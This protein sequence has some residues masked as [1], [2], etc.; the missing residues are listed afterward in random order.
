LSGNETKKEDEIKQT[1]INFNKI[2]GK[3][4]G[5]EWNLLE[6]ETAKQLGFMLF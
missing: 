1:N 4:K 5:E 3:Y 2:F 6:N